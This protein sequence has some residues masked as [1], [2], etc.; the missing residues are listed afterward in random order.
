MDNQYNSQQKF[1]KKKKLNPNMNKGI[2]H[3]YQNNIIKSKSN[4]HTK[5][6]QLY[7]LTQ[8]SEDLTANEKENLKYKIKLKDQKKYEILKKLFKKQKPKQKTF[9]TKL[10]KPKLPFSMKKSENPE[11]RKSKINSMW[12]SLK[13][14][15]FYTIR[16]LRN[17][18]SNSVLEKSINTLLPDNGKPVIPDDESEKEKKHRKLLEFLEANKPII[19]REKNVNI[20]P[21]YFFDKKTFE[22]ILKLK[23]IFLEFD[24]DGSRKMEIDEMF[25]M[26]NQN[27]ISAD[28]N[29]LVKLFFNDDKSKTKNIVNLYLDFFQFMQFAL[30]NEQDFLNFMRDIKEKYKTKKKKNEKEENA[31][32][33]MNFNLVLDYFITKGKERS[34]LEIIKKS[35]D[36]M[37]DVLNKGLS[38]DK[39][40]ANLNLSLLRNQY[41]KKSIDNQD[42]R[43]FNRLSSIRNAKMRFSICNY[44][45]IRGINLDDNESSDD[46]NEKEKEKDLERLEKINFNEPMKEFENLFKAHGLNFTKKNNNKINA[47]INTNNINKSYDKKINNINSKQD[48]YL[49]DNSTFRKTQANSIMPNRKKIINKYIEDSVNENASNCIESRNIE[50][51]ENNSI[52]TDTITNYINK[53]MIKQMNM[54]NYDKFHNIKIAIDKSNKEIDLIKRFQEKETPKNLKYSIKTDINYSKDNS[55]NGSYSKLKNMGSTDIKNNNRKNNF[56]IFDEKK[57]NPILMNSSYFRKSNKLDKKIINYSLDRSHDFMNNYLGKYTE[58]QRVLPNQRSK[59]NNHIILEKSVRRNNNQ[60]EYVPYELLNSPKKI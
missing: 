11:K 13:Y 20:N 41:K 58:S 30:N 21:K 8:N 48:S 29:E 26:F 25:T 18:Y 36:D 40:L 6:H 49:S 33:P 14:H 28:I 23:E 59:I 16:W 12:P 56:F 17:K 10:T 52:I 47:N 60:Y 2:F 15:D 5:Y 35:M 27:N 32:L 39:N 55:I 57:I 42:K 43:I 7:K 31:Y 9:V 19:D 46:E 51:S 53:K 1:K 54:T 50:S 3:H 37:N 4:E 44:G 34:A 22:K 45:N 38:K 24:E